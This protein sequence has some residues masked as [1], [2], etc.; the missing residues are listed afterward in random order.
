VPGTK[1]TAESVSR[2]RR[3]WLDRWRLRFALVDAYIPSMTKSEYGTR[4]LREAEQALDAPKKR[5]EVDAAASRYMLAKASLKRLGQQ[6]GASRASA[7]AGAS[8]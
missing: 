2:D 1:N 3:L 6:A 5:S 7:S 4:E 8:A